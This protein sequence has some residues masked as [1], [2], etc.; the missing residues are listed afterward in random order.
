VLRLSPPGSKLIG[1]ANVGRQGRIMDAL[2]RA[3]LPVPPVL[4]TDDGPVLD[5]RSFVLMRKVPGTGWE[6][7]APAF[8]HRQVAE[9]AVGVLARLAQL[10]PDATGLAGEKSYSPAAEV[11]RWAPL[12]ARSPESIHD[13]GQSLADALLAATPDPPAQASLVHGDFH[14]GNLL[15]DEGDVVAV[16]D[17]EIAALGPP[18]V[19]LGCLAVASLRRRYAPEPNP[20]GSVD[21]PTADLVALAGADEDEAAWYVAAACFKYAAIL[22]YN[23]GLHRRGRRIDPVYEEL[24]GTMRGLLTDGLAI[25]AKGLD[26]V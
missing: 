23:L 7:T 15:F 25:C 26:A 14:Y 17:W 4:A 18:L 6:A 3:G 16:V 21:V 22:G 1:P 5:G 2:G 24:G 13:D 10:G 19:D 12:L 20:T 9:A 8:S 11:E